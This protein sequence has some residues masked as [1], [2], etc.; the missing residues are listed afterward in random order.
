M[1]KRPNYILPIIIFSQFAGTSIWFAVNAVLP[2]L[3]LEFDFALENL[4]AIT[5]SIQFGFII[6]SLL[7][8][9]LAVADRFSPSKVFFISA[10]LGAVLN[11]MII[12]IPL[13]LPI[14][15]GLRFLTGLML[16]GIY[17]VGMKIAA[18]WYEKGL[19]KALGFLV[20]ALVLGTAFPHLLQSFDT[21]LDWRLA[22]ILVSILAAIGGVL[23]L[24]FIPNGPY[25]KAQQ[26]FQPN[27]IFSL[28]KIKK[29]KA[30]AFGYFGH[31]WELYT[32]WA[33]VP[34]ILI[35]YQNQHQVSLNTPL[36]SFII[37][38]F[39]TLGCIIGGLIAI[40]KGS[41]NVAFYHLLISGLC[42]LTFPLAIQLPQPFFLGYLLIWGWAVIADSPQLSTLAA[43]HAPPELIGTGLTLMNSIGFSLTILSIFTLNIILQYFNLSYAILILLIGPILGLIS[44]IRLKER[45]LTTT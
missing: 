1:S 6:G 25:R 20:G 41:A 18:D 42:I 36:W 23:V 9:F 21:I 24:F 33:F 39:G 27:T 14:L 31:M 45:N 34:I 3:I 13:S 12:F 11:L 2:S 40:K 29:F 17:P 26:S 32:F 30:A 35:Y 5:S 44:I 38:A 8:A 4:A 16:A 28:F 19:G 10:T 43:K 22:I 7:F 37:I 15:L